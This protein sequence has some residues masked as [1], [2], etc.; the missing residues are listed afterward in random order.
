M[1]QYIY[2]VK[3]QKGQARNGVIE[4]TDKRQA[5]TILHDRGLIVIKLE[6]KLAGRDLLTLIRDFRGI[7]LGPLANFTRQLSIMVTSGLSLTDSLSILEKQIPEPAFKEIIG[8]ITKD[9]QGGANFAMALAKHKK[10]FSTAYVNMIK[11]G[12]ASG[13]LDQVLNKLAEALEK[14]REFKSK[15]EG[16]F[17]YPAIVVIAMLIVTFVVLVFVIPKLTSLYT[18]LGAQLPLPTQILLLASKIVSQFW[19]A[20]IGGTILGVVLL[21][22]YQKTEI[23]ARQID[24]LVL[25]IPVMGKINANTSLAVLTRTLGSLVGSGVPILEGLKI[26]GDVASNAL[27]QQSIRRATEAV[28]KGAVLSAA[29]G[30][31]PLFPPIV[32]QMVSVGEETGKLDE[33][34][35]K[36][37]HY[38][39]IE[40]EQDIKGLTAAL[41]PI[42]MIILGVMVAFLVISIIL[43]IYKITSSL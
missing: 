37:A 14:E 30:K 2:T 43:P 18:D 11:S 25:K 28:E 31:D 26:S 24:G 39:E 7:G 23:G 4:A 32:S 34:L 27:H 36:L 16:A 40:V 6:E 29:L 21:R 41:E 12:E 35:T 10:V 13:T 42:I 1:E 9:V 8:S 3:D 33:V 20:V 15:I 5:S 38:F 17:I 22:R 19:W